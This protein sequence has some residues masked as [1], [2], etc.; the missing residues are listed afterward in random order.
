MNELTKIIASSATN[1][2]VKLAHFG[3]AHTVEIEGQQVKIPRMG[4]VLAAFLLLECSSMRITREEAGRFLWEELDKERQ[5][6]NLRQLLLRLRNIQTA[7]GMRLFSIYADHIAL[8]P[9]GAEID[10][11]A[12]RTST[13]ANSEQT[14][15]AMCEAYTG[16]LL[17]GL[18][19]HGEKLSQ[20]LIAKR[21]LLRA[22]FVAAI[23][24]YLEDE[25]SP[26]LAPKIVAAK[27]FIEAEPFHEAGYR[28]LLRVSIARG[29]PAAARRIYNKLERLL[30]RELGCKPSPSTHDAYVTL[31]D[32]TQ[33][34]TAADSHPLDLEEGQ[35]DLPNRSVALAAQGG[36]PRV[37][38]LAP[39]GAGAGAVAQE[40]IECFV[41]DLAT[42]LSQ[43]RA[44]IVTLPEPALIGI[45]SSAASDVDYQVDV[46]ERQ[47]AAVPT[48]S[49]R[50]LAMSTREILWASD[51]ERRDLFA[52]AIA[53]M[54]CS[55]V[56]QIE[57]REI[58]FLE[59]GAE[60][61][62]AYRLSIQGQRLL[63]TID[64]P[65]I[66]RARALFKAS[67]ATAPGHI[68]ALAGLAHANVL[69]WLV[70][71]SSDRSL[72]D[73]AE[74]LARLILSIAPDDHRGFREL[75]FVQ[76]Y[77]KKFD[78]SIENLRHSVRLNPIDL[79]VRVDLA[80]AV[81]FR[82]CAVEGIRL[83]DESKLLG[84]RGVD[85][86]HWILAGAY[87]HLENYKAALEE[88]ACMQNPAPALRLSA[89]AHAMLGE[90]TSAKRQKTALMEYN[91][92]FNLTEWLS[93]L[94]CGDREY[95]QHYSDGLRMAGFA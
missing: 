31:S 50:L 34:P 65:S 8:N 69:E 63:R 32:K 73:T 62:S 24:P 53:T 35:K 92:D 77:L 51:F 7:H 67:I 49:V 5:A 86:D 75:G 40:M 38:V 17:A 39:T 36:L 83:F 43:T 94:P 72:L 6:G 41:N 42:R 28:A 9:A 66:R 76:T 59:T 68:P 14:I 22:E 10:V 57:T 56:G 30:S 52:E 25:R 93:I 78:E 79:D 16:E 27:R 21:A 88:I 12:F 33:F 26:D 80:D 74:Q 15:T 89:A 91:P 23:L 1:A 11:V 29:D 48:I 70:R 61:K 82:G 55:I 19:E 71:M 58:H 54:A 95:V 45:G 60:A 81:T 64:L 90:R 13:P 37:A 18:H 47:G 3:Q 84:R 4:L 20:W 85:N 46:R 2:R 44:H 87:Y